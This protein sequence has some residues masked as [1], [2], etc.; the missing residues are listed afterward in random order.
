METMHDTIITTRASLLSYGHTR[1]AFAGSLCS[2]DEPVCAYRQPETYPV[3]VLLQ[4]V[5]RAV[6]HETA[7]ADSETGP[8]EALRAQLIRFG[9]SFG[10]FRCPCAEPSCPTATATRAPLCDLVYTVYTQWY[11]MSGCVGYEGPEEA[12]RAATIAIR[13]LHAVSAWTA[14]LSSVGRSF[15]AAAIDAYDAM[16]ADAWRREALTLAAECSGRWIPTL[17]HLPEI[18][19]AMDLVLLIA[20]AGGWT[21]E[22]ATTWLH[23]ANDALLAL[24]TRDLL[25]PAATAVLYAPAETIVPFQHV[26][27]AV[28]AGDTGAPPGFFA[29][30]A[31]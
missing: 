13:N 12:R 14:R 20:E 25:D 28:L 5:A 21:D 10:L 6:Q 31:A 17:V 30:A 9:K 23:L 19:D 11:A 24:M 2:C 29:F 18:D 7:P 16:Q 27:V 1:G 4:D 8:D 15:I 26:R 22:Q 3:H